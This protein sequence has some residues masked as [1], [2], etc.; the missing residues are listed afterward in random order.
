MFSLIYLLL[1]YLL[2]F[3]WG[4][5]TSDLIVCN[6]QSLQ[7]FVSDT[8]WRIKCFLP[9][10]TSS[11]S[12][13]HTTC[14]MQSQECHF[15]NAISY[16]VFDRSNFSEGMLVWPFPRPTVLNSLVT[17]AAVVLCCG[18]PK[19][20]MWAETATGA[21]WTLCLY[22][23]YKKQQQELATSIIL[24]LELFFVLFPVRILFRRELFFL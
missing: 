12:C 20:S 22:N 14:T 8:Q 4:T 15:F 2:I 5:N 24:I 3:G 9:L 6:F 1:L 18:T 17:R 7:M 23:S 16:L 10:F 11:W 21:G 13:L 19:N